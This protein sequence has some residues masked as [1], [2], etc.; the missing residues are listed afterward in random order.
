MKLSKMLEWCTTVK[1]EIFGRESDFVIRYKGDTAYILFKG[2][3]SLKS[4]LKWIT[5]TKSASVVESNLFCQSKLVDHWCEINFNVRTALSELSETNSKIKKVVCIGYG[6]GGAL[7]QI[8]A[9]W[10]QS[11]YGSKYEVKG[12]SFGSPKV[13]D[14]IIS[15]RV[16]NFTENLTVIINKA[17]ILTRLPMKVFGYDYIS[18][19]KLIDITPFSS[20]NACTAHTSGIYLDALKRYEELT[21]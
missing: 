14:T 15:E 3:E 21:S 9:L 6:H 12:F 13:F 8:C 5:R 7:A 17:D 1:Y 16:K 2:S 20:G 11:V 19:S 4:E 18:T 10:F